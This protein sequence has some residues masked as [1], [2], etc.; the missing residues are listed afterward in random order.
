[1]KFRIIRAVES[2]R[3]VDL[4]P[5]PLQRRLPGTL[6]RG[7]PYTVLVF[8]LSRDPVK[9]GAA[10]KAVAR[11]GV[12]DPGPVLA[13]GAEFTADALAILTARGVAVVTVSDFHW[14]DQTFERVRTS[15]AS[16]R[17]APGLRKP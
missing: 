8:P 16:P 3:L 6:R 5:P 13:F 12:C 9:S 14:T 11:L 2:A 17:K 1:M 4:L 7:G 10:A 15:V